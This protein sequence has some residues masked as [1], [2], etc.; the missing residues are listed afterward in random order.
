[1]AATNEHCA[2]CFDVLAAYLKGTSPSTVTASFDGK[3]KEYPL[4]VTWEKRS[5]S[6][7]DRLRG[8]IGNFSPMRLD[9]GLRE[10]ALT[11]ALRDTRFHPISLSEL[12]KLTCS[13]SLLTDFEDAIDYMDW[14]IGTHGVW[15]EFRTPG[16]RKRTATFLPEIAKEQG[17]SKIETI[18]HLLRKGGYELTITPEFRESTKLT[19]YQSQKAYLP[20]SE[21][22][23]MRKH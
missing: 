19:R 13:V 15:L 23:D 4:F 9:S 12:P 6:G 16:G 17:W 22:L 2:Y 21:Y 14:D 20:Y 5:S 10:Y 8:C 1:M 3:D 11:S 18:D 7:D